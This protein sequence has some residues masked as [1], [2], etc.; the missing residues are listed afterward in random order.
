ML[1]MVVARCWA[2]ETSV[3]IRPSSTELRTTMARMP[4]VAPIITTASRMPMPCQRR[5]PGRS[6]AAKLIARRRF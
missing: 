4:A 3:V 2:T 5:S 6:G 1:C